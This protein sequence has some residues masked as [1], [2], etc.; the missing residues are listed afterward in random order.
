M[1]YK[2]YYFIT[3]TVNSYFSIYGRSIMCQHFVTVLKSMHELMKVV[4]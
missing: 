4:I 1:D 3:D 2:M